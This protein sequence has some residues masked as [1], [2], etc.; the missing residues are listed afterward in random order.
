M[1]R[2]RRKWRI[3]K[4]AGAVLGCSILAGGIV[5]IF[6]N[7]GVTGCSLTT[8]VIGK[9][10]PFIHVLNGYAVVGRLEYTE[11]WWFQPLQGPR[12]PFFWRPRVTKL[13]F[14]RPGENAPQPVI[15]SVLLIPLWIPFA[16]IVLPTAYL[17]WRDR[18]RIPSGHCQKCGYD[19][20]GNVSGVC[21]E[22]GEKVDVQGVP[23][24]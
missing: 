12:L 21:P 10:T 9:P 8:P 20:T 24:G 16:I 3:L 15:H 6:A 22:C 11:K 13:T 14:K 2:L 19:L 5:S 4:W 23:K 17:F 7:M 1:A 18:C